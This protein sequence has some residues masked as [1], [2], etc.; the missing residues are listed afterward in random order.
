MEKKLV[1]RGLLLV[2]FLPFFVFPFTKVLDIDTWRLLL[3]SVINTLSLSYI[4]LVPDLT[5]IFNDIIKSKISMAIFAFITWGLISYFYAING[6]EV[7]LRSFSFVN[8]YVS[9]LS[10]YVFIKFNRFKPMVIAIFFLVAVSCEMILSYSAYIEISQSVQYTFEFNNFLNGNFPNRN[11]TSAI[12]LIQLPFVLHV[13]KNTESKILQ[14]ATSIIAFMLIYM[15]FMLG[16]R[17]AYV[18]MICLFLAYLIVSILSK[19]KKI[20][21]Y[22]LTFVFLVSS[23]FVL[24]TFTLGTQSDAYAVNRIQTIDFTETSTNTRLRYYQYGIEQALNNPLIGVGLGNWKIVSIERDKENII[25]YIV[26]YTMHNDFLEVAAE[27]GIIGLLIFLS[28]FYFGLRNSWEFYSRNKQD[29]TFLILPFSLLIYIIDSNFNFPFTRI[30]QLFHLA[31][32][33]ALS[34]YLNNKSNENTA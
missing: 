28:I 6:N 32:F 24:S 3:F 34:V 10:L 30:S 14:I 9:F 17:T 15:V 16:S 21:S 1:T 7:I 25:S 13:L 5:N 18:I 33:L 20:K 22:F 23:S 2:N 4:F 26:P 31:L 8:F 11:I 29:P 19:E 12:Y 27:L